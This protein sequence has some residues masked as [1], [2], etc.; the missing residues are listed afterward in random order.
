MTS[1]ALRPQTGPVPHASSHLSLPFWQ[2]CR[3][4]ELW[5]Q[6][7]DACGY[8][9]F[10]PTEHCRQ[11]LSAQV[12]WERSAGLGEIYSWTVVHRPVTAEFS[13]PYAPAIV[14]L[15]E[16]YQMLT[17]VVGVAPEELRIG[18]RVRV[19]F[20]AVAPDVTLPYFTGQD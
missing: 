3:S 5:Y 16:G 13:P 7:C 12:R 6:R 8:P 20:H 18:M 1:D 9:N 4:E 10:P 19:Q 15:D 11:C 2:G 14:T 17:N